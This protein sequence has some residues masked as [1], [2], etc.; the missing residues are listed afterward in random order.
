MRLRFFIGTNNVCCYRVPQDADHPIPQIGAM[1][2]LEPSQVD[3]EWH[4]EVDFNVFK[5]KNICYSYDN[6]NTL[7]DV[8]LES[9]KEWFDE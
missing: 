1:V 7:V 6:Q 8:F 4:D 9:N 2:I 3:D 5:V